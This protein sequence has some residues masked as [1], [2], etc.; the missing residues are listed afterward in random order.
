[1]NKEKLKQLKN[2]FFIMKNI[3][4]KKFYTAYLIPQNSIINKK[5]LFEFKVG[6]TVRDFRIDGEYVLQENYTLPHYPLKIKIGGWTRIFTIEGKTHLL[7]D[8]PVLTLTRRPNEE[9]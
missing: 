8:I 7:D 6:D 9:Q 3:F 2:K 5:E 1:M 4:C